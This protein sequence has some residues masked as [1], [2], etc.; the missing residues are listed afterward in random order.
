[1]KIL[2]KLKYLKTSRIIE[3]TRRKPTSEIVVIKRHLLGSKT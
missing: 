1:M 3:E 2:G